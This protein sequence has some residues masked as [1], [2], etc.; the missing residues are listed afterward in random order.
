MTPGKSITVHQRGYIE[1]VCEQYADGPAKIIPM[2]F[3]A[4]LDDNGPAGDAT[5]FRGMIGSLLFAA[6]GTRP[7]IATAVSILS[8]HME[9]P[10]K[11]HVTAAR[12]ICRYLSGCTSLGLTYKA[13][14][15]LVITVYC[16]ASFAPEE[17]KRKS[18]SGWV[19]MINDTPVAWKSALQP[20]IA[21]STAESE[22]ISMSE[23]C[24]EAVFIERLVRAMGG[25]LNGPIIVYEDNQ[26]AKRMAE[27]V[28]TKRSKHIDIRY[29][30]VREL[31]SAGAI[32]IRDCRSN[33]MVAD[34]L[35]KPLA[36]DLFLRFRDRMMAKEEC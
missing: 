15:E 14:E 19:V 34:T 16:D 9:S 17:F 5:L 29:H 10:T 23:A 4:M 35:T 11:A 22:Y 6:V 33:D 24:R 26:T 13:Q 25:M 20:I 8:R 36:K 3:G 1:R 30:H 21:H 2:P 18:R 7:D 31:A 12:N 27:E 32:S 28:A